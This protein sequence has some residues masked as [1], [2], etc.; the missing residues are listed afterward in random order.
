M[1][2]A[3]LALNNEDNSFGHVER[4]NFRDA[5]YMILNVHYAKRMPSITYVYGLF[6][7]NELVGVCSFGS[8]PSQALCIGICGKQYSKNVIELNRLVLLYNEKNQAS[9]FIA[10]C[11]KLLPKP[12]IVV[13]Y[14][15]T[16]QNHKGIVY[17]ASN[18]VYTGLSEK[19]PEW[20]LQDSNLHSKT[21]CER[22]SLQERKTNSSFYVTNR[23]RKHRYILFLGS[24]KEKKSFQANFKYQSFQYP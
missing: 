18:F 12:K 13:S 3:L 10:Q 17:Q 9:Y 22:Y 15:D 7:N 16:S 20:R 19:R 14:A 8:P 24:K 2:Q 4:I 11:L 1:N 5:K 21:L 6:K 23:P